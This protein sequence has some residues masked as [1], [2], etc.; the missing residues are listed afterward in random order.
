MRCVA[1][2]RCCH[3]VTRLQLLPASAHTKYWQEEA[4]WHS[5]AQVEAVPRLRG[6]PG[7]AAL[8]GAGRPGALKEAG[9]GGVMATTAVL[10][11]TAL[12]SGSSSAGVSMV[13]VVRAGQET[14]QETQETVASVQETVGTGH[15][16]RW[17]SGEDCDQDGR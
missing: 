2:P 14:V 3:L 5:A 1:R 7:G 4:S 11:V 12:S 17:W 9:R 13:E 8:A 15:L 10:A 16:S 6:N